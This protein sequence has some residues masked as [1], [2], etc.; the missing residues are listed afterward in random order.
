MKELLGAKAGR[1]VKAL[2]GAGSRRRARGGLRQWLGSVWVGFGLAHAWGF[3][4]SGA[5]ADAGL[6]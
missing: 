3:D 2:L 1:F 6:R 5:D 4:S